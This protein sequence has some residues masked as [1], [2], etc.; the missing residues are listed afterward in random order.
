M[1]KI[2]GKDLIRLGYNPSPWFRDALIHLNRTGTLDDGEVSA[3]CDRLVQSLTIEKIDIR[4]NP[5]EYA[6]CLDAGGGEEIDNY[7]SVMSAM[8]DAMRTPTTVDGAIMPDACPVGENQVPV[9]SIIVTKNTIHPTMHSADVCCSVATSE[10]SNDVDPCKIMDSA[11]RITHFGSGGRKTMQYVLED[12]PLYSDILNN[13][14]TKDYIEKACCHLA[15]QGDGNHFLFVGRSEKTGKAH[16]VTHHG[17][18][19]FGASVYKRAL[20]ESKKYCKKICIETKHPWL[21]FNTDIG[22]EYWGALQIIKRWTYLNHNIIH[23]MVLNDVGAVVGDFY[24]NEHNF[25]FKDGSEFYHAKGSTPMSDKFNVGDRANPSSKR[26]IPLNMAQPVLVVE[27]NKNNDF[28]FAPHGAGRNMSR[29]AF[30]KKFTGVDL[31]KEISHLDIR[32]YSGTPDLSEL[33]SAYKNADEVVRQ[34]EKFNLA[35]IVDKIQPYG[36]IMAGKQERSWRK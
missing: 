24:W 11:M 35:N 5:I 33:P 25:V 3:Y 6:V 32:F 10:I 2:T 34:I 30:E 12:D 27:E 16:I 26:L 1:K 9:G 17:S 31:M 15:T 14:F 22:K 19:G 29:T 36:C 20:N 4:D 23:N 28:G 8:S 18:R 13:Y 7:N 21:D